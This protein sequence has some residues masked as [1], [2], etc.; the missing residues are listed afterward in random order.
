MPGALTQ[1]SGELYAS[2]PAA[3]ADNS[4]TV[5]EAVLARA[6]Q[7]GDGVGLWATGS[8]TLAQSRN[9]FAIQSVNSDRWSA[10]GGVDFSFMG[11]RVGVD[12]GYIEDKTR[13]QRIGSTSKTDTYVIGGHV[14]YAI[15]AISLVA[16]GDY[17]KHN[18]TTNRV[19]GVV[20]VPVLSGFAGAKT[21]AH[22][23]Q[24]YGEIGYGVTTGT[25]TVMPF[26]RF[27]YVHIVSDALTE[28]GGLGALSVARDSRNYKFGSLGIRMTGDAPISGNVMFQPR[29]SAAYTRGYDIRGSRTLAFA[30]TVP[31]FTVAGTALARDAFDVNAGFDLAFGQGFTI[32]AGGFGSTSREWSDY[33]AKASIGLKF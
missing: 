14:G 20:G 25:L 32:G 5:R 26:A 33:G 28:G 11:L 9:Q 2:L 4:K 10:I 21:H 13:L 29:I 7:P 3:L 27:S 19:L 18:I 12:G 31:T 1:L 16:G 8:R 17:A 30:G 6:T 15:G 22:T 24:G 23:V